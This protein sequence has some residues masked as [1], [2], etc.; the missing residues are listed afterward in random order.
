MIVPMR[1]NTYGL[2]NPI[3]HFQ[4]GKRLRFTMK[5]K[6]IMRI[7]LQWMRKEIGL[8]FHVKINSS[9]YAKRL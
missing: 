8:H 3:I 1:E 5:F 9:F 2:I 4:I 7:A 6:G